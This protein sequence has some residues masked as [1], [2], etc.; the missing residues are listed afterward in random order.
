[1]AILS[2]TPPAAPVCPDPGSRDGQAILALRADLAQLHQ[3]HHRRPPAVDVA[4]VVVRWLD[5]LGLTL[6]AV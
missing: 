1:M 5:D 3:Q 4:A 6:G 2:R